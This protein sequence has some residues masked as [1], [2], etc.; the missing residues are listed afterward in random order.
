MVNQTPRWKGNMPT[1]S[2]LFWDP[3]CYLS[4][5]ELTILLQH[6]ISAKLL[7]KTV[8]LD[9]SLSGLIVTVVRILLGM[10]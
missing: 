4:C 9:F 10:S 3:D 6:F 2:L 5:S 1:G 7:Y 8:A